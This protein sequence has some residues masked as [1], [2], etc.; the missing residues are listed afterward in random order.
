ME[1]KLSRSPSRKN[2]PEATDEMRLGGA[3][4]HGSSLTEHGLKPKELGQQRGLRRTA[5]ESGR[6]KRKSPPLARSREGWGFGTER[7][8]EDDVSKRPTSCRP[9]VH[10]GTRRSPCRY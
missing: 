9:R 5:Q 7:K 6:A 10:R 3:S 8:A 2:G 4:L 1:P